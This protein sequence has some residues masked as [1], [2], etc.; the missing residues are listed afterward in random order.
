MYRR[1]PAKPTTSASTVPLPGICI[2][3]P[4]PSGNLSPDASITSPLMRVSRPA[5]SHG[6]TTET[7]SRQSTRKRDRSEEF[8][9]CRRAVPRQTLHEPA[10]EASQGHPVSWKRGGGKSC[11]FLAGLDPWGLLPEGFH[12]T[13]PAGG[14][15]CVQMT[16]ARFDDH[17]TAFEFWVFKYPVSGMSELLTCAQAGE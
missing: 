16:A 12:H 11:S 8:M 10:S 2:R 6:R 9:V 13:S 14:Q 7:C 15:A 17:V 5:V 3:H 1:S 4:E